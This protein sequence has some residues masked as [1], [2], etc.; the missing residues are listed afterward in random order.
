M[1][2]ERHTT[3][4]T[5]LVAIGA[6]I[7][8]GTGVP[9]WRWR[10][11]IADADVGIGWWLRILAPA[12]ATWFA[13]GTWAGWQ[14]WRRTRANRVRG[15]HPGT[16]GYRTADGRLYHIDDIDIIRDAPHDP[17]HD[18]AYHH[19]PHEPIYYLADGRHIH[20]ADLDPP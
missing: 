6:G 1:A 12:L 15:R 16:R 5:W 18:P 11:V 4:L 2:R 8:I 13:V 20:R 7:I 3:T 19:A 9:L 14:W 10:H 17:A